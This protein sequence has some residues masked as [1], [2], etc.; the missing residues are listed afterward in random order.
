MATA[1]GLPGDVVVA[2]T[3][4]HYMGDGGTTGGKDQGNTE[5]SEVELRA[6]HLPAYIDAI[7][8]GVLSVMIS[9]SSWNGKKMHG[10]KYLIADVLK[11]ELGFKG[12]VVSDWKAIDQLP[13]NYNEQVRDSVNAGLDM[14]MVPKD[15]KTCQRALMEEV[16]AGRIPMERI[17]DAVSRILSMKQSLGLFHN[18]CTN[19]QLMS[20]VGLN[21]HRVLAQNAVMESL[22][23]LKNSPRMPA[24]NGTIFPLSKTFS[25][26]LVAGKHAND[27]GL[28]CGGWTI[29]WQGASGNTTKGTTILQGIQN[30]VAPTTTVMYSE[31][32]T[33][34]EIADYGIVVVGE[35]PYAEF[36]GDS[37][38][39]ELGAA[40]E[41]M[42]NSVCSRMPCIVIIISGR[43]LIIDP[44][45][46]DN[47][48]AVIAAWLPG[49]EAGVGIAYV[50]FGSE[51]EYDFK[52]RLPI[53]WPKS[54]DQLPMPLGSAHYDPLFP[55][56]Y[57]LN[58]AGKRLPSATTRGDE[59]EDTSDP[60]P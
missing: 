59:E 12:V 56:G 58:K 16:K 29:T 26:I 32:P 53:S 40:S 44:S 13:G 41:E 25:K 1:L 4:K 22:V 17:D 34:A 36:Q 46:L 10:N 8:K 31:S 57:G 37:K 38:T 50:L 3:A 52:G 5:M 15:F 7:Q 47:M 60:P 51:D 23:L 55:F 30:A 21:L 43:P 42:I 49:S 14:I 48:D 20:N 11:G 27:I 9:Y 35:Q 54:V 28:Q 18:A 24:L 33:G 2:A 19:R 39:L 45:V 6:V